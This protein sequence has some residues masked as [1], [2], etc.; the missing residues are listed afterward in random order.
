I[1]ILVFVL[2]IVGSVGYFLLNVFGPN[3]EPFH[4]QKYFY[5][6]TGSSYSQVLQSLTQQGI[7]KN[8][9]SFNWLAQSLSLPDHFW[10]GRYKIK[11]GMSNFSIIKLLRSGRQTPVV[12]VIN[13]LRT[14]NDFIHLI[15]SNL[16]TDSA[17]LN[18]LL[19]DQVYLR[20]FGLDTNTALC[21]II[22]DT[23]DFYWN[24]S[25]EKVFQK[26]IKK[27][28]EFWSKRRIELAQKL[29]LTPNQVI[30][31]SSIIEEETN[32]N[33][34]KP[35]IA[36]VYLNRLKKGM[37]LSADPTLKYAMN[38][39]ALKR[40][41]SKYTRFP[42]PYNTYLHSGLPPGPICTPSIKTLEAV[43]NTKSTN[44]LYF[45]A[46]DDFS[47]YH[48]FSETYQEQIINAKKYQAALNKMNIH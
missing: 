40:I 32:K 35:V 20:Q 13:K 41:Y 48:V 17:T 38:D 18:E 45:C 37:R 5:I 2:L 3:T 24:T 29:G 33:N 27:R 6:R 16:E 34:E 30:I 43:L 8:K 36:S 25:A 26:L 1:S 47:G 39:F 22:P 14:K 10:P 9:S 31:L 11:A 4:D 7:I 46:K 44:Y 42:S 23:Y 12:L 28:N 19:N 21:A 15:C